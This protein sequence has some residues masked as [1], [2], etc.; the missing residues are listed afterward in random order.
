[1]YRYYNFAKSSLASSI[2]ADKRIDRE[3]AH[4][5]KLDGASD[6][7]TNC[8]GVILNENF[9]LTTATCSSS[10]ANETI[11]LNDNSTITT[12]NTY[13]EHKLSILEID[14]PLK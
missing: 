3:Y 11:T 14:P 2:A 12:T 13:T 4:F 7:K 5:V 8:F 1:M 6:D 9:I 10:L